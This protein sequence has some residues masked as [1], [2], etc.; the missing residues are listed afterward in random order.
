M[1]PPEYLLWNVTV[2]EQRLHRPA[3]RIIWHMST[4]TESKVSSFSYSHLTVPPVTS[5][6]LLTQAVEKGLRILYNARTAC[7][8]FVYMVLMRADSSCCGNRAPH[9]KPVHSQIVNEVLIMYCMCIPL[10]VRVILCSFVL[11]KQYLFW[12]WSRSRV[13]RYCVSLMS[14]KGYIHVMGNICYHALY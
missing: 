2:R 4:P 14:L 3:C 12:A 10:A 7:S 13:L 6:H 9:R 5:M 11:A 8:V 1:L